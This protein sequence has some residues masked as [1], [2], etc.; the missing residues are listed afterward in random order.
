[1]PANL[2]LFKTCILHDFAM[3]ALVHL[4]C[5]NKRGCSP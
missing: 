3:A 4:P 1:M 5:N 2:E